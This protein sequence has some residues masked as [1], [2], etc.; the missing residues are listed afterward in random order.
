MTILQWLIIGA[1]AIAFLNFALDI[2]LH[3]FFKWAPWTGILPYALFNLILLTET[4][5]WVA[6]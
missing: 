1:S 3:G 5:F 2:V 4:N 6:K